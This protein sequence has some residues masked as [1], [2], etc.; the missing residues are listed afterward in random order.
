MVDV[1]AR[2]IQALKSS[3]N[4]DFAAACK[5]MLACR[6]RVVCIGMGKSGHVGGKI[7][8]TLASTGTP[9]FF[10]HPG[11]AS[12]GTDLN[13]RRSSGLGNAWLGAYRQ[14]DGLATQWRAGWDRYFLEDG[15]VRVQLSAQTATGGFW[16]GVGEPTIFVAAPAVLNAIFAATGKRIRSFPLKNHNIQMA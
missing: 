4:A 11:E 14:N 8:A 3:V 16:G 10:V 15:P 2:A 12:H 6:G 9:A 13:L 7:A 5:L 1:E